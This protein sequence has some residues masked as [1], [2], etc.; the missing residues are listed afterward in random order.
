MRLT[1]FLSS[2]NCA[3]SGETPSD[4]ISLARANS[5]RLRAPDEAACKVWY[6]SCVSRKISMRFLGLCTAIWRPV[7][8]LERLYLGGSIGCRGTV[9][10]SP[11]VRQN[12]KRNPWIDTCVRGIIWFNDE[13]STNELSQ[14]TNPWNTH[15]WRKH[16]GEGL[17][18][19]YERRALSRQRVLVRLI[20]Y[21]RWVVW[22]WRVIKSK[23]KPTHDFDLSGWLKR[24]LRGPKLWWT[25]A[26]RLMRDVSQGKQEQNENPDGE[27]QP[28]F[29]THAMESYHNKKRI[30]LLSDSLTEIRRFWPTGQ[31]LRGN[32]VF[33]AYNGSFTGSIGTASTREWTVRR[34][35]P[36]TP[37]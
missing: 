26:G 36:W 12:G 22:F 7:A 15:P 19:L 4:S 24:G 31:H 29:R 20:K 25:L 17:N 21:Y 11:A 28:I 8:V 9:P 37:R 35:R 33:V 16:P 1:L 32:H 30:D 3:S 5:E 10:A 34:G 18:S 23:K 6:S 14:M 27:P 2:D 13:Q